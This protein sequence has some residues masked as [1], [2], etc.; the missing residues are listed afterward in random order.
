MKQCLS[1]YRC[2]L[3][4]CSM[5]LAF[6]CKADPNDNSNANAHR[7][8]SS[9][10]EPEAIGVAECD[11]YVRQVKKCISHAP[12]AQQNTLLKN[13]ERTHATWASLASNPGT[14]SSLGPACETA[15]QTAKG[16]MQTLS[17]EW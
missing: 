15:L 6:A 1:L 13:L 12:D 2:A 16:A 14:R 8:G 11:A 3:W 5:Q 10:E 7:S 9:N 17:C 4:I